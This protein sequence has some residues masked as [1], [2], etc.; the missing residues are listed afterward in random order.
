M[1]KHM[2]HSVALGASSLSTTPS[3]LPP[4]ETSLFYS[5]RRGHWSMC[6]QVGP[7]TCQVSCSSILGIYGAQIRALY[8]SGHG[9]SLGCEL[10]SVYHLLDARGRGMGR[11]WPRSRPYLTAPLGSLSRWQSEETRT[12]TP[13]QTRDR[14][15]M[16]LISGWGPCHLTARGLSLPPSASSCPSAWNVLFLP[17]PSP[18]G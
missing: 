17:L 16:L 12:D 9:P 8:L 14:T 18:L 5:R 6:V 7:V 3:R 4:L 15:E 13:P 11:G 2:S 1:T 10:I